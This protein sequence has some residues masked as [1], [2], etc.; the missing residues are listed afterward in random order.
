[1]FA[2][3]SNFMGMMVGAQ[4]FGSPFSDTLLSVGARLRDETSGAK[5]VD[6]FFNILKASVLTSM[7]LSA[8]VLL[9]NTVDFAKSVQ[10]DIQKIRVGDYSRV[11]DYLMTGTSLAVQFVGTQVGYVYMGTLYMMSIMLIFVLMFAMFFRYAF[12]RELIWR[13]VLQNGLVIISIAVGFILVYA[14]RY[15]IDIWFVAKLEKDESELADPENAKLNRRGKALI[16]TRYWLARKVGYNQIDYWFLFPNLITGLL[17]FVANLIIMILGSALYA[18][19]LDKKT[20]YTLPFMGSKS[21]IYFSWLLQEHHHTNPI[22]VIFVK[23]LND[24]YHIDRPLAKDS[25]RHERVKRRWQL[26]YTLLKNPGLQALRK[27]RVRGTLLRNYIAK[28][29][30]PQL[31]EQE[32]RV[33]RAEMEK[34]EASLRVEMRERERALRELVD[35]ISVASGD[36][37]ADTKEFQSRIERKRTAL[38]RG[39]SL[40]GAPQGSPAFRSNAQLQAGTN[41]QKAAYLSPHMV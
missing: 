5:F 8:L 40:R 9:F 39:M 3:V 23:L 12:F 38:A 17:S 2:G 37:A 1:M 19:R 31:W 15:T 20:E 29:E 14:Q 36:V 22:L 6:E 21:T 24:W 26:L 35:D 27:H 28:V 41:D 33:A 16:N 10:R 11:G 13:F 25:A 7:A 30:F 32:V 18:Y 34:E 4:S